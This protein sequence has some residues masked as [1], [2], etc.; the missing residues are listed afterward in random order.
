IR[1][2]IFRSNWFICFNDGFFAFV[3]CLILYLGYLHFDGKEILFN[4]IGF[5][6]VVQIVTGVTSGSNYIVGAESAINLGNFVAFYRLR[7]FFYLM[8]C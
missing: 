6:V 8:I 1:F 2:C 4:V 5:F 7:L 3:C